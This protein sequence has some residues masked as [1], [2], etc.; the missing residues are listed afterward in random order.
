MEHKR[1]QRLWQS[2]IICQLDNLYGF[3]FTFGFV[4]SSERVVR[5]VIDMD[6]VASDKLG[7]LIRLGIVLYV[8]FTYAD[9]LVQH[10]S[11]LTY[12]R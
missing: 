1:H 9:R 5:A 4:R 2:F 11:I 6:Y 3:I 8:Q 7:N 12:L 10:G